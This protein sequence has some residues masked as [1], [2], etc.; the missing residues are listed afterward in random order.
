[1]KPNV[2]DGK[3]IA[4]RSAVAAV[5]SGMKLGLGSGSTSLC[6]VRLVAARVRDEGLRVVGV[7]TSVATEREAQALGI[8]LATLDDEPQLDL[9][10]DGADQVNAQ[11]DCIKGYGGALLR[12]KIVAQCAR[13]FF[14]MVDASKLSDV[15]DKPV[16]VEVLPFGVAAARRGLESIGGRPSLRRAGDAPY[17]TDNGNV[18]LDVDFGPIPAPGVLAQRIAALPGVIDHG[19]FVG[20]VT[21]LHVGEPSGARVIHGRRSS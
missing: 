12:E 6:A 5:R 11:L 21:E 20:L 17:R 18:V 14:V 10:L 8:P 13:R 1:V 2:A 16:P 19:L 9:A 3:E 7:P 15:L 4:A